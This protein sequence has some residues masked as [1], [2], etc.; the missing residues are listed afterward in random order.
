MDEKWTAASSTEAAV[1]YNA[2][3]KLLDEGQQPVNK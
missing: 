2:N 1:T 3:I